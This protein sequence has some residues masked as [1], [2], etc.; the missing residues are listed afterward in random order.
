MH[1]IKN[2]AIITPITPKY[3]QNTDKIG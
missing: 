2:D 1:L 3:R